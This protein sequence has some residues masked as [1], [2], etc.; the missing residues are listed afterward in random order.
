MDL[1]VIG[2]TMRL[3]SA[4]VKISKKKRNLITKIRLTC[5]FDSLSPYVFVCPQ[6]GPGSVDQ[7]YYHG[8]HCG[9]N[10]GDERKSIFIQQGMNLQPAARGLFFY[11]LFFYVTG[12]FSSSLSSLI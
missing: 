5:Y 4:R 11:F 3:V 12:V 2:C 9:E 6:T 10:W 7:T 8:R 1:G